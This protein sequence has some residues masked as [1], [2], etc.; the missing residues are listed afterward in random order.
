MSCWLV[1]CVVCVG[2]CGGRNEESVLGGWLR[3]LR[4]K[5]F[6]GLLSSGELVVE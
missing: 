2:V 5:E 4:S 3:S 6:P 1:V